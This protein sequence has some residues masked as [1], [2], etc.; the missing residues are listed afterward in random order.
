MPTSTE[1][2]S[3]AQERLLQGAAKQTS[4]SQSSSNLARDAAR[5]ISNRKAPD[6]IYISK[7]DVT[8]SKTLIPRKR[9][10][11]LSAIGEEQNK[12]LGTD[13]SSYLM[14]SGKQKVPSESRPS[15][16]ALLAN[17][18]SIR[19]APVS[20]TSVEPATTG[21]TSSK[22]DATTNSNIQMLDGKLIPK[23]N[24]SDRSQNDYKIIIDKITRNEV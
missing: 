1:A 6:A 21:T 17:S 11:E 20:A 8:S 15:R 4:S 10:V 9:S 12:A 16:T 18:Q 24:N 22:D 5:E 3:A 14:P 2:V 13:D 7:P 19:I 23:R